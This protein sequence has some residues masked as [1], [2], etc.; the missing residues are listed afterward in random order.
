MA[1]GCPDMVI[2]VLGRWVSSCWQL[3]ARLGEATINK[4]RVR[5]CQPDGAV[6]DTGQIRRRDD[7]EA[8]GDSVAVVN[9]LAI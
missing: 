3:Y 9:A 7:Q 6:N 8:N 5:M 2:M 4:W 1:A